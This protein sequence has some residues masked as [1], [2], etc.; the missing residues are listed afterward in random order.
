MPSA[1]NLAKARKIVQ[2]QHKQIAKIKQ[3]LKRHNQELITGTRLQR[4]KKGAKRVAL[5]IHP[6]AKSHEQLLAEAK[7]REKLRRE[8]AV[9]ARNQ[10]HKPIPTKKQV[11]KG[12]SALFKREW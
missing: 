3:D 4:F 11:K 12:I 7:A 10:P 5:V 8:N 6:N 9:I 2:K 1:K